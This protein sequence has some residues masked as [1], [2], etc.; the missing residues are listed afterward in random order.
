MLNYI[1]LLY[2][3]WFGPCLKPHSVVNVVTGSIYSDFCLICAVY[4]RPYKMPLKRLP[5][6]SPGFLI[7]KSKKKKKKKKNLAL[8]SKFYQLLGRN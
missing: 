1:L 4:F 6:V 7:V 8:G 5:A 2:Y 3:C